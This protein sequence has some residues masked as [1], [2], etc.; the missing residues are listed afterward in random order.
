MVRPF[1]YGDIFLIQ[2]LGRQATKLNIVQATLHR[3]SAFG[4]SL[5][6]VL[7]WNH[8]KVTT[9]ILSQCGHRLAQY[10]FLQV[11]KRPGRPELD[12][13]YLAP[14]LDARRGHPAIWEKLLS[15]HTYEA[16]NRQIQRIYA[17]VPD[18]PLPVSTFAQAGYRTYDR[19]TIWRLTPHGVDDYSGQITADFRPQ[20]SVDE[21]ALEELYRRN[22]PKA[23]QAAEGM[24][25]GDSMRPPILSWWQGGSCA[26]YVLTENGD[27]RGSIQIVHGSRGSWLQPW[28]DFT[29]PDIEVMHQLMRFALTALNHWSS[30]LPVYVAVREHHGAL[31]SVLSDY[32]FAP[33][34]DR[35]M[36]VKH[37]F[38]WL[39]EATHASYAAM[40]AAPTVATAPFDMGGNGCVQIK[41]LDDTGTEL[42]ADEPGYRPENQMVSL[43]QHAVHAEKQLKLE[44]SLG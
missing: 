30:R 21:W 19:Q 3:Q 36:M 26:S 5:T 24:Q 13:V 27:V 10:G 44:R 8:G 42:V 6:S 28:C 40:E 14:G 34:T 39:R 18:Q 11:Q 20:I 25:N 33:V 1:R 9:Y 2:R 16:A 7:P 4:A 32:S 37:V 17:D 23:V 41:R 38:Q 43:N 35:A 22:V 12:T 15:Y 31:G 29:D